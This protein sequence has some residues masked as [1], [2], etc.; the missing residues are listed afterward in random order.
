MSNFYKKALTNHPQYAH[1]II[2][3]NVSH[4]LVQTT[5]AQT[6]QITHKKAESSSI[7]AQHKVIVNAQPNVTVDANLLNAGLI[8]F[9]LEKGFVDILDHIYV[10]MVINN[11]TGGSVTLAPSQLMIDR[12]EIYSNNGN[13]L[14]FQK[15][16]QEMWCD[17]T[18]FSRNEWEVMAGFFNSNA[19]YST[20]GLVVLNGV[21]RTFYIPLISF[22]TPTK[23]HL[24]GLSG[25][26]LIRLRFNTSAL[27]LLAGT[28]PTTTDCALQLRGR[29]EPEEIKNER[30][31]SYMNLHHSLS[32]LAVQ[33]MSQQI[34]LAASS[35]Y[36]VVLS[37]IRGIASTFYFSIRA[38]PITATNQASYI[39]IADWD[40]QEQ[41]G[42]S[43]VGYYRRTFADMQ[44]DNAESFDN[45]FTNNVNLHMIT[46]TNNPVQDYTRGSNHG[47]HCFTSFEKLS[48]TTPSVF[49]AGNYQIDIYASVH[50]SAHIDQGVLTT[51]RN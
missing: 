49:T 15:Y 44:L 34:T 48:F 33:R 40:C 38:L 47:Y 8:E 3:T 45:L 26:L 5:H 39:A 32:F 46:F 22:F 18:Y 51:S 37:G 41:D 24:A 4:S 29:M 50:E 16:G 23:L 43:S 13:K 36:S 28:L 12:W 2:P 30:V 35:Q 31:N 1:H 17:N 20:T 21:S 42:R 9:R 11:N 14:I 25:Q 7:I 10:K 6:G 27:T 19:Q